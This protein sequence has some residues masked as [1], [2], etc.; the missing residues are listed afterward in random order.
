MASMQQILTFSIVFLAVLT[1]SISGFG[2][3]LVAMA[4]LPGV[5]NIRIASPLVALIGLSI[6]IGLLIRYHQD[7]NLIAMWRLILASL[8]GIP[9]GVWALTNIGEDIIL[10]LL[11]IVIVGYALYGLLEFK[12]PELNN[13]VWAYGLGFIAGALGGAYNTSGPPV[14]IYGNS[15]G[16]LPAEFK[17][18]LQSFFLIN[19]L[20][21]I[22]DHGWNHNLTGVVFKEYL[23]VFPAIILGMV[24]GMS[25]D[26]LINPR[27]FRKI[28]FWLLFV[29]GLRLIFSAL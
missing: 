24:I 18:N 9:L 5:I 12:M 25:L 15:K 29:M 19:S 7:L 16:W 4:F 27:I 1:Q 23:L 2:V 6:E 17:S 26:R 28:L 8:L 10:T 22:A 21:V 14:I 13:P 3:A 20:L 11:G